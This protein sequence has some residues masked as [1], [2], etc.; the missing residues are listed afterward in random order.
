V[1]INRGRSDER[2]MLKANAHPLDAGSVVDLLTGGGGGFGEPTERDPDRV[3]A[4]VID[5]YVTEEAAERDY[6]VVFDSGLHVDQEA[7][8]KLRAS[9]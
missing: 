4:D 8:R 1:V 6:G 3:R 2:R 5:G 7:T 9:R